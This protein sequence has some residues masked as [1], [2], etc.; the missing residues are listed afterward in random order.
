MAETPAPPAQLSDD[1]AYVWD[2][3]AWRPAQ[4]SPDGGHVWDGQVWRRVPGVNAQG[5]DFSFEVG[6]QEKHTVH[7]VYDQTWGGLTI[8]VDDLPVIKRTQ[9]ISFTTSSKFP[10]TVGVTEKHEVVIEKRR[11][12]MYAGLRPQVAIVTVDGRLI[13]QYDGSSWVSS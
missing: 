6:D 2:G 13:G 4:F 11:K 5:L 12:L 7:F 8:S 9:I 10:F 1:R 3:A